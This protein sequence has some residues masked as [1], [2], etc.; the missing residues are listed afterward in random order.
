MLVYICC[1]GASGLS[2]RRLI[3]CIVEGDFLDV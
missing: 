1:R 2:A 3:L